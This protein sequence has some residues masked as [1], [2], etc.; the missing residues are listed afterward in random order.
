MSLLF[1][2]SVITSLCS[3]VVVGLLMAL[4]LYHLSKRLLDALSSL[5][6]TLQLCA[7]ALHKIAGDSLTQAPLER[8]MGARHTSGTADRT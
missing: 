8:E 5:D 7:S 6:Q 3:L 1:E 4:I 2:W